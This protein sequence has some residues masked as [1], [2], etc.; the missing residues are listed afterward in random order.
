MRGARW[1][2]SGVAV[3]ALGTS[4]ARADVFNFAVYGEFGETDVPYYTQGHLYATDLGPVAPIYPGTAELYRVTNVTGET[5]GVAITGLG[6]TGYFGNDN[7]LYLNST[8]PGPGNPDP[9]FFLLGSGLDWTLANGYTVDVE[10]VNPVPQL[11]SDPYSQTYD[12]EVDFVVDV[13]VAATPE[14]GT[15]GLVGAGVLGLVGM[16]RRRIAEGVR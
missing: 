2:W 16:V 1:M 14:P 6:P 12:A 9:V 8:P 4:V 7:L 5:G 15:M 13:P 10:N 3:A 11:S